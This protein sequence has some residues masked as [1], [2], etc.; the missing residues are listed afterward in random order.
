MSID[1][2]DDYDTLKKVVAKLALP[3]PVALDPGGEVLAKY[4]KGGGIPLT[5]V[6]DRSG[7]VVYSHRN[8]RAGDEV[9]LETAL[10]STL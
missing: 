1:D 8:F 7:A 4:A 5:F 9:E 6:L 3:Y 2:K 10:K